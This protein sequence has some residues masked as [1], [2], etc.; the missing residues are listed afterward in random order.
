[1]LITFLL[2]LKFILAVAA[3]GLLGFIAFVMFSFRDVVPF[4]PTPKKVI[5]SMIK[6][7]EI[8]DNERIIDL[9]SGSGRIILAVAKR[10]KNNLITGIEKSFTLRLINKFF[11]FFHPFINKKV[12]ILNQDFFNINLSEFDV[13][14]CFVTPEALRRLSPKFQLLKSG[15]RVISYMFP[16]E[17]YQNFNEQIEEMTAKDS[18]YIYKKS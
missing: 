11:L 18:I 10:H 9:G 7:A 5:R 8:T 15:S 12:Q 4:V 1:M 13:I 3:V 14:L 16:L 2:I 6:L 17:N